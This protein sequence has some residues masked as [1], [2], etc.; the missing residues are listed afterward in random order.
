MDE[1]PHAVLDLALV[2]RV[3]LEDA[4]ARFLA[5][6]PSRATKKTYAADLRHF[7]RALGAEDGIPTL[8]QVRSVGWREVVSY[9]DR[10]YAPDTATGRAPLAPE[11]GARRL[12]VLHAFYE[13][14]RRAG[15]VRESPAR[16]VPRPRCSLE[17]KT[18]GLSPAEVDRVLAS[19]ER[20]SQRGERDLLLLSVLFF[21]WLRV[22][23]AVRLRLDDLGE[24]GGVPVL[25][26][27]Q[28][29]GRERVLALRAE[30]NALARSYAERFSVEGFLFPALSPGASEERPMT[31]EAARIVFKRAC[32]R[33]GLD[34]RAY[35]PHSARVSG[36]TAALLAQAPLDAVQD[37]AGHARA[38]TTLRY[39]RARR[40]LE[41]SPV[42][43]LPFQLPPLLPSPPVLP[44][45]PESRS[46]S[47]RG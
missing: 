13:E 26:V 23:E 18:A 20:G 41:R 43:L 29:G 47:S 4:R 9:R 14:L 27:R 16:D 38:E 36:I 11:T 42:S 5:R 24:S 33:A 37:F 25:R 31:S 1:A 21:Q 6:S 39:H 46:I 40:R 15:I 7:F 30:V 44:S 32:A 22:S 3:E 28:K 8:E 45:P 17:G 12:A 35:S 2:A 34:A 10:F 19:C